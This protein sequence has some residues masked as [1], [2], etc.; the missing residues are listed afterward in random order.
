MA[1]ESIVYLNN[2]NSVLQLSKYIHD[3]SLVGSLPDNKREL[4]GSWSAAAEAED[5]VTVLQGIEEKLG[6]NT[7]IHYAK[8]TEITGTSTGEFAEAVQAAR[9]SDAA[10]VVLGEEALMSGEAASRATLDLP[11][12]QQQLLKAVYE[13]GTPVVFVLMSGRPLAITWADENVSAILETWFLGT[14]TGHAIADVL[15]GDEN[16]SGKLPVTF[17]RKAGQVPYHYDHKNTGRPMTDQ[18]YT[19]KYIDVENSSLYPFGHGLSYTTFDY[20]NL[21]LSADSIAAGDTLT[22]TVDLQNS[23]E[24]TGEEVVQLYVRDMYASITQP[25]KE[26]RDFQK[27]ELEPGGTQSVSFAVTKEDL[28]F[29]NQELQ[30]VTEPGEFRIFVGTNANETLQESFELVE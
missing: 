9:Q 5:N 7:E 2:E 14:E 25:V 28:S 21:Q 29:Y 16:P 8:G 6:D 23:G 13:T 1:R 10:V 12:N 20:S 15:F 26:L 3:L 11:G 30:K 19:S 27:I 22:V 17:P 4:P 24:R 18:K